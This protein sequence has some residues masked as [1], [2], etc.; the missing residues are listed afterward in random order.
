MSELE[1]SV[2]GAHLIRPGDYL[3]LMSDSA[4]VSAQQA[5]EIKE[6]VKQELPL[7]AGVLVVSKDWHMITFRSEAGDA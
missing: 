3:V 6:R 2:T 4:L 1:I 5:D 7:L